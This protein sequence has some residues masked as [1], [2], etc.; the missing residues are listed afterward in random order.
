MSQHVNMLCKSAFFS[1][2]NISKIRKFL[3]RD[4]TER[5]VHAFIS[6]KID[7]CNSILIG[8]PNEEIDKIQRVQNAAARL[9]SG[10]K[11]YASITPILIKLHWLP[12]IARIEYKILLTVFKSLNNLA[13]EYIS[14]LYLINTI[15]HVHFALLIKIYLSFLKHSTRHTVIELSTLPPPNYGTIYHKQSE[16][17]TPLLH[18]SQI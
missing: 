3:D 9:I 12:V 16:T 13:P 10:T 8:L 17:A 15:L 1:L 2:K 6:S 5:L 14:E 7:Y 18:L 4:N 11:K